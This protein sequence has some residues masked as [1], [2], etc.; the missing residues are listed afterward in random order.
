MW[1]NR[2]NE[3]TMETDKV[4]LVNRCPAC[5][6]ERYARRVV[7]DDSSRERYRSFSEIKYGGLLDGWMAEL[8]PEIVVCSDC[9]H[10]WYLRQ[11]SPEQLSLMYAN[12]RRLLSDAV[13]REPTQ[14]MLSE[15]RRLAKLIGKEQPRLLDFGSGFGRWAR[16]AARVGFRVQAYEPSEARGTESV[17][18]FTLVHDLSEIAGMRFDVINL[19]Q[20]LEHVPDPVDTLQIISSFFTAGTVLRVR[21][22]NILRPPEGA[23]VWVNWPYDG[24]RV[25][26][27]APFEHLHGFTPS[28]LVNLIKR[29][30]Y[31]LVPLKKTW[32][33]YTIFSIR[34]LVGKV[35]PKAAQ[36]MV[37]AKLI[38]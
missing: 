3:P 21:V 33:N 2:T 37:L 8:Q 7:I 23:S 12:G 4:I 11:P 35:C 24:M 9:G 10:H 14:E 19:E 32:R 30:G 16:A 22:P 38:D 6:S 25:H 29:S 5:E 13:S 34:N 18:E 1:R 26:A 27:M 17:E 20:V 31:E 36:T 28:S 15:M